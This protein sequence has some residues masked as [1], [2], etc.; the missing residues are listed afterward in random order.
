MWKGRLEGVFAGEIKARQTHFVTHLQ[1]ED[2]VKAV[3]N[4]R[5]ASREGVCSGVG[6]AV[7]SRSNWVRVRR[8]VRSIF[9]VDERFSGV[10]SS[11]LFAMVVLWG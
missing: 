9:G 2:W 6:G 8:R 3:P 11:W 10:G 5:L 1:V 7:G 4:L